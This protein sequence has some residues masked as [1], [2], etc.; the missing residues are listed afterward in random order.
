MKLRRDSFMLFDF[1]RRFVFRLS[2][3]VGEGSVSV[4]SGGVSGC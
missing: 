2:S 4:D 1:V 3:L